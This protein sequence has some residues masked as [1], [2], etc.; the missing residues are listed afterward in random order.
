MRRTSQSKI[1]KV[2]FSHFSYATI[3]KP[4]SQGLG[5]H[6]VRV[7]GPRPAPS[8]TAP[9]PPTTSK[10]PLPMTVPPHTGEDRGGLH[11]IWVPLP[12]GTLPKSIFDPRALLRLIH[13]AEG[14]VAVLLHARVIV[15]STTAPHPHPHP[16][17]SF[18]VLLHAQFL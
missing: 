6:L 17:S 13:I 11:G 5:T 4:T 7:W 3:P 12:K 9:C 2:D 18:A 1:F 10:G 14:A 16:L 15:G 8:K